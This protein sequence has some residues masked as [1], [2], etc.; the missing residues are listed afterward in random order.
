MKRVTWKWSLPQWKASNRFKAL[1][2]VCA[3][4]ARARMSVCVCV[5]ACVRVCVYVYVCVY[6]EC[7]LVFFWLSGV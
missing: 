2:G 1:V 7:G 5:R 6:D 4:G 3:C